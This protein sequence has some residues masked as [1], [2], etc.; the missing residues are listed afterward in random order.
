MKTRKNNHIK[1][2]VKRKIMGGKRRKG[3]LGTRRT[4]ATP[5]PLRRGISASMGRTD[6]FIIEN[7]DELTS[8]QECKKKYRLLKFGYE[9]YE[10]RNNELKHELEKL[11]RK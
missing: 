2:S 8:L 9:S 6:D 4:I 11:K 10:K 5:S 7:I 1:R 3:G